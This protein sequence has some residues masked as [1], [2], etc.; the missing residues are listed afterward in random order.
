MNV[1]ELANAAVY[2]LNATYG[3]RVFQIV[4][5][6][7]NYVVVHNVKY[8]YAGNDVV[9]RI[10]LDSINATNVGKEDWGSYN[11]LDDLIANIGDLFTPEES[12]EGLEAIV[13]DS[14]EKV[15]DVIVAFSISGGGGNRK[16]LEFVGVHNIDHFIQTGHYSL[17][18]RFENMPNSDDFAQVQPLFDS[19]MDKALNGDQEAKA[20][21]EAAIG[22][23][24]GELRWCDGSGNSVGL[25]LKESESGIGRI[26]MDGDYDTTYCQLLVDCDAN[27]LKL[28]KN[29]IDYSALGHTAQSYVDAMVELQDREGRMY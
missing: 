18:L 29:S 17:F 22:Y 21:I 9:I 4:D 2:W 10:N 19:L 23:E 26:D 28:I 11:D 16:K 5:Q 8:R 24:L 27:E 20:E 25:T 3:E 6:K 15:N 7:T 12:I 14:K 1:L 13:E